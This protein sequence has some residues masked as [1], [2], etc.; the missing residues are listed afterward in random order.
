MLDVIC[1][2]SN[3]DERFPQ[4]CYEFPNVENSAVDLVQFGMKVEPKTWDLWL[5]K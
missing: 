3:W 1:P 4:L 5:N 2:N